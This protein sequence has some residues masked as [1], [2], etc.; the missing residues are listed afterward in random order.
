MIVPSFKS[1]PWKIL[2]RRGLACF[3]F[4]FAGPLG[5][6]L[7]CFLILSE[8]SLTILFMVDGRLNSEERKAQIIS[9]VIPLFANLGFKE[10]TTKLIAEKCGVSEA[11]VYKHFPRKEDIYTEIHKFCCDKSQDDKNELTNME[12]STQSLVM[13]I[14]TIVYSIYMNIEKDP[15]EAKNFKR[16]MFRSLLEEGDFA[17]SFHKSHF[18]PWIPKIEKCIEAAVKSGDINATISPRL[19]IYFTHHIA[20]CLNLYSLPNQTVVNYEKEKEEIAN[21]AILFALRGLGLSSQAIQQYYNPNTL[22][23]FF[24][25]YK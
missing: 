2:E 21:E 14:F 3:L 9:A 13:I 1:V 19:S 23:S 12:P 8:Y 16:L 5:F 25:K 10:T 4:C 24:K 17:A 20:V 11:L 15:E 22:L 6:A 7:V 18:E